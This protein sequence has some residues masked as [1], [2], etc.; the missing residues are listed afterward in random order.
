MTPTD[1]AITNPNDGNTDN[2]AETYRAIFTGAILATYVVVII[3]AM[4]LSSK[5]PTL[6]GQGKTLLDPFANAKD[7]LTGVASVATLVL[8]YWFG[9][10]G[11]AQAESVAAQTQGALTVAIAATPDGQT[12]DMP[13]LQK[14][15][16]KAFGLKR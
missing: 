15:F 9:A 13:G 4:V 5:A 1:S 12:L 7:L 2:K 14:Q 3:F 6:D 8:G 10:A 16:P 11:K